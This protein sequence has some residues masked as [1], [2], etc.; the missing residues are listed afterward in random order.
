MWSSL[1]ASVLTSTCS[2]NTV[3]ANTHAATNMHTCTHAPWRHVPLLR[4]GRWVVVPGWLAWRDVQGADEAAAVKV[5]RGAV[6]SQTG[7]AG[8][9]RAK[10]NA[11]WALPPGLPPTWGRTLQ[12]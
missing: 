9:A 5:P 4:T 12:V 7:R 6:G 10:P 2:D 3:L 11:L 1:C 8:T